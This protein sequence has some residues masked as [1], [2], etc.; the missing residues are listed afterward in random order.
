MKTL[1]RITLLTGLALVLSTSYLQAESGGHLEPS[2]VNIKDMA[3]LQ[4]G[5]GLFVNYCLS[6]HSA[7]YMRLSLIH[8]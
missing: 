5:A 1:T 6:C 4:R 8:I 3:A 2:G 7:N